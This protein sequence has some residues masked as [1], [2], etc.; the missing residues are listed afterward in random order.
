MSDKKDSIPPTAD[1]NRR[2]SAP[3]VVKPS[4]ESPKESSRKLDDATVF[5]PRGRRTGAPSTKPEQPKPVS[6]GSRAG[7]AYTQY[8]STTGSNSVGFRKASDLARQALNG[9][10][11]GMLLK[12]RFLLEQKLGQG[13]MGTVYKAQDLR[14]VEAEDPNPYIATKVLNQDFKDHPDA[15]VTLQQ[16]AAKSQT[17]AHPNIVTVHDFDRDGDIL[18]MTME[19]LEGSPLD[20]LVKSRRST[21]LPTTEALKLT[22]DLCAALAYAHK[23]NLIHADFKPGNIFVTEQGAAKV[24][25]FGIARAASKESQ[26]HKFDAGELGALTPAYATIEMI[27]GEPISFADDVYA[28]ACVVYEMLSGRHPYKRQS[29]LQAHQQKLRPKRIEKLTTRQWKALNHALALQK[30]D[31]TPTIAQF[32]AELFP[33]RASL[34]IKAASVLLPVSLAGLAWFAYGNYEAKTQVR[35]TI[36][37][38]I[39]QA[40]TCFAQSQFDCTI[41][42][43][44]VVESIDPGNS[45]A[46]SLLKNAQVAYKNQQEQNLIAGLLEEANACM[47]LQDYACAQIKARE[48]LKVNSKNQQAQTL[49]KES[50]ESLKILGLFQRAEGC[51]ENSNLTCAESLLAQAVTINPYHQTTLLLQNRVSLERVDA[52]ALTAEVEGHLSAARNCLLEK[53]FACAIEY[54]NKV[55]AISPT[56]SEAIKVKHSATLA[57]QQE[58]ESQLKADG[59]LAQ[60]RDCFEN[61]NYSC[62][63]AKAEAA[64]HISPNHAKAREIKLRAEETQQKLKTSG[65][66]IQ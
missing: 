54:A 40:Q 42:H 55:S 22:K 32:N 7:D 62:A 13:G 11:A 43:S 59:M 33:R 27:Q 17:L 50:T 3:K 8:N 66:N 25:D 34:A 41:E 2:S 65:F 9:G 37:K 35:D 51:L 20:Q 15:F 61:K 48:L 58:I 21:G 4:A 12:K 57:Q 28:L 16:E 63:I 23:H 29:A 49:L 45:V 60:A 30:K 10:G 38:N 46:A 24:L 47:D 64:L 14:K 53:N 6:A 19:L 52:Q 56:N 1:Q 39:A 18:F 36:A 31:R 5:A 44:L 26:R